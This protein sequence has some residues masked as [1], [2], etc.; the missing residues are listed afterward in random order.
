MTKFADTYEAI[1]A[2]VVLADDGKVAVLS[3]L[4]QDQHNLQVQMSRQVLERLRTRIN[5]ALKA[6]ARPSEPA[7]KAEE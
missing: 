6:K 1:S 5:A 3:V 2:S 4:T 7:S